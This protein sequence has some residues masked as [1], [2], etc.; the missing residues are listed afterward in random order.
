MNGANSKDEMLDAISRYRGDSTFDK[1]GQYEIGCL[2][3]AQPTFFAKGHWVRQPSDWSG[4]IVQGKTYDMTAGEGQRIFKECQER[5]SVHSNA[6]PLQEPISQEGASSRYGEPVLICP[7]LGQG[8][9]RVLVTEAYQNACCVSTEHSLPVLE[10][11]HI[12]PYGQGGEHNVRN[13]LLLRSDIHK[14]FDKGYVT[15]TP[16]YHFEVSSRLKV[17]FSNGKTYY[18]FHGCKINLPSDNSMM[19]ERDLLKWHNE[20]VFLSG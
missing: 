19:P 11:A 5:S 16:D 18:G 15:V 14:L 1:S 20:S 13:G 17:D 10:A 6:L 7:R 3:I 8:S 12:L 2:L 4:P 9:F